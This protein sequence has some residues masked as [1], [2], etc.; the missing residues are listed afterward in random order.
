MEAMQRHR[1][2]NSETLADYLEGRLRGP[3]RERVEQHLSECVRCIEELMLVR[4]VVNQQF[5][6]RLHAVPPA[7]TQ[8]AITQINRNLRDSWWGRLI[9]RINTLPL[10]WSRLM[11]RFGYP[12]YGGLAPVRGRQVAIGEDVVLLSHSFPGID[13]E[14]EIEKIDMQRANIRVVVF[15]TEAD[16]IPLRVSL[17]HHKREVASYLIDKSAAFFESVPFGPYTLVYTQKGANIG[18]CTFTIKSTA[19]GE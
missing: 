3:E 1:C 7:V 12:L 13:A 4:Q 11:H 10:E 19:D 15:F 2:I 8:R 14:V 6:D 16:T 5:N 9:G 18:Q 17:V